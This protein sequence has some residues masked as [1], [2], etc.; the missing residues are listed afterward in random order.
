M[1]TPPEIAGR[2]ANLETPLRRVQ[3][4][5]DRVRTAAQQDQPQLAMESAVADLESA[6]EAWLE[7]SDAVEGQ[8]LAHLP[9]ADDSEPRSRQGDET[10]DAMGRLNGLS[11]LHIAVMCDLGPLVGLDALQPGDS[12]SAVLGES[13]DR[14]SVIQ[15]TA[16]GEGAVLHSL[17][18]AA[19]EPQ[20]S[21][22]PQE[23]Q[24]PEEPDPV[25]ESVVKELIDRAGRVTGAVLIGLAPAPNVVFAAVSP[26]LTAALRVAPEVFRQGLDVAAGHITRLIRL[27]MRRVHEVLN[28]VSAGYRPIIDGLLD[29]FNPAHYVVEAVIRPVVSRVFDENRIHLDIQH[30][31]T[32]RKQRYLAARARGARNVRMDPRRAERLRRLGRLAK[33]NRRWVEPAR[34]VARGLHTLWA[35]PIGVVPAA[36]VVGCAVLAWAFLVTG[37]QLDAR[38][39]FPNFWEGVV[40]ISKTY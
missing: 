9:T 29:Y 22:E 16:F 17:G 35:V 40:T 18:V 20:E 3:D 27:M 1:S 13:R 4:S 12:M 15:E 10:A 25:E 26:P 32:A 31:R 28:A 39:A 33:K 5:I 24:E 30:A 34:V 23:S 2:L 14:P 38:V 8:L 6:T 7:Q 19:E 21:R 36:P 37:D 11:L